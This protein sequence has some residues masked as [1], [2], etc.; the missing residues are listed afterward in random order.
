M[1]D[2]KQEKLLLNTINIENR[3]MFDHNRIGF[4]L[5]YTLDRII[6]LDLC[7]HLM[8]VIA[9]NSSVDMGNLMFQTNWSYNL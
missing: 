9:R 1:V 7:H 4:Q 6:R 3:E 8:H 2:R 5:S